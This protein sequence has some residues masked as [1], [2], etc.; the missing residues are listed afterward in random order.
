MK[1]V[2]SLTA[3]ALLGG[4]VAA[5]AADKNA[6]ENAPPEAPFQKVSGLVKLPDFIPGLG[7]LFVDPSTLP[8]GPFLA[9]DHDGSLVS[10]IYMIPVDDLAEIENVDH[11]DGAEVVTFPLSSTGP[12]PEAATGRRCARMADSVIMRLN[13]ASG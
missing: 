2:I 4:I 10:T 13:A 8:A 6:V 1:K 5:S 7:Q 3:A 12:S 11:A 9:Y